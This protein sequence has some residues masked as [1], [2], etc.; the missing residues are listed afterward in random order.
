MSRIL[1]DKSVTIDLLVCYKFNV[2][3]EQWI[4]WI[5]CIIIIFLNEKLLAHSRGDSVIIKK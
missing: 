2:S 1:R 4:F 3:A 5:L